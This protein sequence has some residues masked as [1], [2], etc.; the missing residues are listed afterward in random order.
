MQVTAIWFR[1][2]CAHGK[3]LGKQ[4]VI[5]RDT[6]IVSAFRSVLSNRIGADRYDLWFADAEISIVEQTIAIDVSTAFAV[7]QIR[8]TFYRDVLEAGEQAIGQTPELDLQVVTTP[9]PP[10]TPALASPVK[11]PSSTSQTERTSQP[12]PSQPTSPAKL[13]PIKSRTHAGGRR[14]A[15]LSTFVSGECNRLATCSTDLILNEF[16]QI[17]P[18]FLHGPSGCGKTHLLEGI[19]SKVRS[20]HPRKRAVF[21]S[22]EQFTTYFLQALK[23]GG[24]PSFRRKYR[25]VD[26]LIIDDI[27]FFA[28]KQATIVELLH[29]IDANLREGG[30][31]ILAADRNPA[32]LSSLGQELT[33]RLS[34]GLACEMEPLDFETRRLLLK[35]MANDRKLDVA[36]EV[37][38]DVAEGAPGDGRQLSG[39]LNRLWV[40]SRAF[41]KPINHTM[42]R[43]VVRELF[44]TGR[45]IVRLNDIEKVICEEF[46][47]EPETL[48]SNRRSREVS[49]PRMLA[50]WLARKHTRAGL[51]EI[52]EF[53]GRRSHSTVLSAKTKVDH[54]IDDESGNPM[55]DRDA[56]VKDIV[57][58]IE[59]RLKTG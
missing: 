35:Q 11:D 36:E 10:A 4:E 29:T 8:K 45:S 20:T 39:L 23:G 38:T 59:Q 44:P 34:S 22:A 55:A 5:H 17:S 13:L 14:F 40:S 49:H 53:F 43:E 27:Q 41:E 58:R 19:W 15:S 42:A 9:T 3:T 57:R 31:L 12:T 21:L 2:R 37:L 50:M 48:K 28:G 46:S 54:W 6:D 16:G 25:G 26:L 24:L 51:S 47:I 56:S 52:S 30:Q 1:C 33:A 7:E 18:F 32:R